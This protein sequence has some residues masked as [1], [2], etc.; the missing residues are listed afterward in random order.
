MENLG[1]RMRAI[2]KKKNLTLKDVARMTDLTESLI[3]QIENRKANP[4]V[5]TL[6]AISR[7][8]DVP[9]G[10]FFDD[11]DMVGGP[12]IRK[13]ERSVVH[14]A[15]GIT[16]YLMNRELQESPIE[17]LWAEYEQG[18]ST[19][20]L[21]THE[22]LECGVVLSGKLE[23][24]TEREKYI[25]NAGDSITLE[26]TRPHMITNIWDGPTT[27]IWINSPPTF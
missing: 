18:S 5:A 10:A 9:I 3:S 22:G 17:V 2:R 11:E 21:I 19:G 6:V 25:L 27:A 14:T 7:V 4:S 23:V 15:S 8:L 26:S 16:Y 13:S 1:D 20:K 24:E 12:V